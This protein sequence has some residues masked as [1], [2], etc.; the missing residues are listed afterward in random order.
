MKIEEVIALKEEIDKCKTEKA[1]LEGEQKAI[2]K[3]LEEDWG[4]KSIKQAAKKVEE[5]ESEIGQLE[6]EIEEGL[7]ELEEKYEL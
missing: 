7:Q 6:T 2:L 3:Q 1:Q 5:M 4:C